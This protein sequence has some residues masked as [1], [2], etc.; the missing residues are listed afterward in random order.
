MCGGELK[1][2]CIRMRREEPTIDALAPNDLVSVINSVK[3]KSISCRIVRA[4][5][6]ACGIAFCVSIFLTAI[7]GLFIGELF[8]DTVVLLIRE[9]GFSGIVDFLIETPVRNFKIWT[10]FVGEL[11]G[12]ETAVDV[13]LRFMNYLVASLFLPVLTVTAF[14]IFIYLP[15]D[16]VENILCGMIARKKG[17]SS[18]DTVAVFERPTLVYNSKD[19]FGKAYTYFPFIEKTQGRFLAIVSNLWFYITNLY[20][21]LGALGIF[22]VQTVSKIVIKAFLEPFIHVNVDVSGIA[23]TVIVVIAVVVYLISVL[24]L[25]LLIRVATRMIRNKQLD[26]WSETTEEE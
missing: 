17:Y 4:L 8:P 5:K 16:I 6:L 23:L 26:R 25:V 2:R 1:R 19:S 20:C 9:S 18:S 13:I 3:H 24:L 21:C 7:I 14:Y 12:S 15:L 22:A 10:S 11:F